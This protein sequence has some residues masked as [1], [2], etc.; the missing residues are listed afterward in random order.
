M[1]D[2]EGW[3]PIHPHPMELDE[4]RLNNKVQFLRDIRRWM[5]TTASNGHAYIKLGIRREWVEWSNRRI[6][7]LLR[8][9]QEA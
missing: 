2:Q 5:D 6:R 4:E 1:P 3:H 7:Y 9:R 8:K